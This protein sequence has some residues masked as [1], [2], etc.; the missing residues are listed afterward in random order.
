[1][2]MYKYIRETWKKPKANLKEFWQARLREWK[3][4]TVTFRIEH[5]TRLDKARSLGYRAKPGYILIRQRVDR[6]GRQR[7]HD[8]GGRRSKHYGMRKDLDMNYRAVAEQR[9]VKPYPNC[10]VLNSY[11]VGEDGLSFW[12][13]VILIDKAHPQILSDPRINWI[14]SKSGRAHRG[15]TSAGRKSRGFRHKGK[16]TEHL[17]PSRTADRKRRKL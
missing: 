11:Y 16:G 9:A 8:I 2:G 14:C 4:Q 1:M 10:E 12:Y 17:R 13:E 6:G 7:S 5:P 15:L 3:A